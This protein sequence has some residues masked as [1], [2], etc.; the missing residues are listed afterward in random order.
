MARWLDRWRR[1]LAL[2][3]KEIWQPSTLGD[4][5]LRGRLYAFLRVFSI[6]ITVFSETKAASRAAALSFSSLLGLGPLVA[7][8]MLVAGMVL[9]NKDPDLAVNTLNRVITFIAPQ[10]DQYE[11]MTSEE[12]RERR[13]QWRRDAG[14]RNP[15]IAR[16]IAPAPTL[17]S[18][19]NPALAPE[20]RPA[21]IS[22]APE[23]E[24]RDY[25][26]SNP[27]MVRML[28]GFITGS[29][30]S[31]AGA[32]GALT[33]VLIVILLF[34]TIEDA[35]NEIWGVREGRSWLMRIIYYWTILTLGAVLFF[36]SITLLGAGAFVNVFIGKLPYGAE[37]LA[38]MRWMLPV[39]SG[40]LVIVMLTLFYRYIPNTHVYW[41]AAFVGALI[42]ALL[43]LANN[44][45]AFIYVKRVVISRSLY[46][47]LGIM[48]ILMFGLYIF[49]LY[50][51]IG[52]QISY[53][54]Q[55]ARFRSSQTAWSALSHASREGLLLIVLLTIGRRFQNCLPACSASQLSDMMKVPT[56]ILN[57][58]LQRLVD[59][60]LV[61]P[62]PTN[63]ADPSGDFLYQPARP[64]N[65]ITL[66]DFRR[67][68]ETFGEEATFEHIADLD[69]LLQRYREA[70][71]SA[72]D[73]D[74]FNRPL[75]QLFA[76][77]SFEVSRPPFSFGSHR[78]A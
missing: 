34:K 68:F 42:V 40:L 44:F 25:G 53:A 51:L 11:S 72:R 49:W 12:R 57:E 3:R 58:C 36:A 22:P 77:H 37:L 63:D 54:V 13:E 6:T 50:V 35:F 64:L 60:K 14:E 26:R 10:V 5:S 41:R 32:I 38:L 70:M 74:F 15:G 52:G 9:D 17:E 1:F 55:N 67:R 75:D 78:P 48:P 76:E 16:Q 8:A 18:G 56:Q 28:N 61:T 7:I 2:Y 20:D 62:I 31:T 39:G 23:G 59:L 65:R 47:S 24:P 21:A 33:L 66:S 73:N 19:P 46:G 43:L 45:L 4:T 29:R 69:P 27:Q 30:S 71:Q